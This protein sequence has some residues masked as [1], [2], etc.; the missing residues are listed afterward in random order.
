MEQF[1]W[2]K[3]AEIPLFLNIQLEFGE[4][5]GLSGYLAPTVEITRVTDNYIL[6][7]S[8]YDFVAS[9]PSGHIRNKPMLEVSGSNGFYKTMFDPMQ[10]V[11]PQ[12]NNNYRARFKVF[13]PSGYNSEVFEDI[14]MEDSEMHTFLDI[15]SMSASFRQG[16]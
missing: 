6:D 15:G 12:Y 16:D 4:V 14:N 8:S 2:Q 3:G 7:W 5:S 13:I 11:T 10:I 9:V 1:I